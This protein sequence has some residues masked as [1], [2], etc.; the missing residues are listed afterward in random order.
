M[1]AD[2]R[3]IQKKERAL[4]DRRQK[5]KK[6]RVPAGATWKVKVQKMDLVEVVA[7]QTSMMS[8]TREQQST[9]VTK[10]SKIYSCP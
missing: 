6:L 8:V 5:M 3:L 1:E 4:E 2:R 10:D 7:C 9:L